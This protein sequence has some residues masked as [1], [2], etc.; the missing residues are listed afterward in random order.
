[1]KNDGNV[2]QK[3]YNDFTHYYLHLH[4]NP[5]S[6]EHKLLHLTFTD[7]LRDFNE[8]AI[9][10]HCYLHL[11]QLNLA[12]IVASLKPLAQLHVLK[13]SQQPLHPKDSED[14]LITALQASPDE[15]GVSKFGSGVSKFLIDLLFEVLVNIISSENDNYRLASLQKWF[16]AYRDMVG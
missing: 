5:D 11:F 12:K 1:M 15:F 7:T 2:W 13:L 10:A 8:R 4:A 16:N 3:Y 14:S 9:A 6:L